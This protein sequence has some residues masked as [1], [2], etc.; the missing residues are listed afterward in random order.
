MTSGTEGSTE[1][2]MPT[3]TRPADTMQS[4]AIMPTR[5]PNRASSHGAEM[6][7][8]IEPIA[9][10]R[11]TSPTPCVFSPVS[12]RIAGMRATHVAMLSPL[13]KKIANTA[14]RHATS[15]RVGRAA[16]AV[17]FGVSVIASASS[18]SGGNIRV[19]SIRPA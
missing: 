3:K 5:A 15:S 17:G 12:S 7:P 10:V 4:A 14:L 1:P 11:M 16:A 6:S 18:S 9:P 8:R 19:E 13:R 2:P